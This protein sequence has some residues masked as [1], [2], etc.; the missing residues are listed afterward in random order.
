LALETTRAGAAFRR[1]LSRRFP[2]R[3][4]WRLRR[5]A[6]AR[7]AIRADDDDTILAEA[8]DVTIRAV[9]N[10]ATHDWLLALLRAGRKK[11]NDS[12]DS[13][14][15]TVYSTI[16]Y[17]DPP[18]KAGTAAKPPIGR[19]SA[20]NEMASSRYMTPPRPAGSQEF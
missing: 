4:H 12:N 1:L 9:F 15:Q 20:G 17:S 2:R 16:F 7:H 3:P 5:K 18:V 14:G 11:E 10:R 13:F 6:Q 8:E 19:V